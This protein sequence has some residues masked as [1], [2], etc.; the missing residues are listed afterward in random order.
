MNIS[1][2]SSPASR[3]LLCE[4]D[5]LWNNLHLLPNLEQ[6][7]HQSLKAPLQEL[8][9]IIKKCDRVC[10]HNVHSLACWCS[11]EHYLENGRI[12]WVLQLHDT[13]CQSGLSANTQTWNMEICEQR[14]S[15]SAHPQMPHTFFLCIFRTYIKGNCCFVLNNPTSIPNQHPSRS[16][17]TLHP[18]L[19][20]QQARSVPDT[21]LTQLQCMKTESHC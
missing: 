8:A 12:G 7:C 17:A 14:C 5:F 11:Q 9:E 13:K 20:F 10:P 15:F 6:I 16:H 4:K 19:H 2:P 1:D 21:A 3:G 18:L